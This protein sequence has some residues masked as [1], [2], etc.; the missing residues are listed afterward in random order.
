MNK[1]I[2]MQQM[3]E[4]SLK[5]AHS[6]KDLLAEIAALKAMA[7]TF[8]KSEKMYLEWAQSLEQQLSELPK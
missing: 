2:G 7:E 3:V 4:S 5:N 8:P 1:D 6:Q